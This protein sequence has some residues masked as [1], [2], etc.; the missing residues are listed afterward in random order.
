MK[1]LSRRFIFALLFSI[2]FFTA[3]AIAQEQPERKKTP[4]LTTDD[5]VMR[6][7]RPSQPTV[8]V[9][10]NKVGE[11]AKT[12]ASKSSA[13]AKPGEATTQKGGEAKESAEEL[14][15]RK[16]VS[17]ARQ[18]AEELQRAAEEG[19]IRTTQLR[20]EM[21]VS[22]QGAKDRNTL[23]QQMDQL[24]K[25]V[26]RLRGEARQAEA[27]LKGLL[28]EGREKGY[29]EEA[30][31]KPTTKDGKINDSY[32]RQKFESLNRAM[33]D[34]ERRVLLYENRIRSL[35]EMLTNPNRDRFSGSQLDQ[36]RAEAQ[37]KLEEARTAY[38]KAQ[39]DLRKLFDDARRAG[40][41]PGVF[42]Q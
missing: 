24:G 8:E 11:P 19:E 37:S 40:V 21:N 2:L 42:R 5:V 23:A 28:E 29:R 18:R 14:S 38:A 16:Q 1:A 25:E 35:N 10:A 34:A 3:I 33:A 12:T 20:N 4:R 15:W 9:S 32:Y 17:E 6:V 31:P 22:G 30:G 7:S 39:D 36:D 27:A 26:S 13:P 41:D